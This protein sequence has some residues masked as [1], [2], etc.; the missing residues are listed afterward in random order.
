[1]AFR[2]SLQ[3]VLDL[4][5]RQLDLEETKLRS[6]A[7]EIAALDRERAG[8]EA[9]A[10][11]AE[12]QVREWSALE[13]GDLTALGNFRLHIQRREAEIS[14][15]RSQYQQKLEEQR[16][17][18]LEAQRRCRVVER[19]KERRLSEW[20]SAQDREIEAAAAESYLAQWSRERHE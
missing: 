16:K 6:H 3:R 12:L 13:G 7:A 10:I 19:L 4:R 14:A 11:S 20:Q 18:V 8:L 17:L 2:F 15:R 5:R 1:M 9:S